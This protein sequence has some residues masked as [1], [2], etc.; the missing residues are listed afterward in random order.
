METKMLG[1]M[2]AKEIMVLERRKRKTEVKGPG[3]YLPAWVGLLYFLR[4]L[5]D[6]TC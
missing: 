5:L 1:Y 3:I 4:H 2:A 6:F